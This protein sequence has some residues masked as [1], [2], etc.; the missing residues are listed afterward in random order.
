M[1]IQEALDQVETLEVLRLHLD[2]LTLVEMQGLL[3]TAIL[4]TMDKV[5]VVATEVILEALDILETLEMLVTQA[6]EATAV[7]VEEEAPD[8]ILQVI[9]DKVEVVVEEE[10]LA[11][12]LAILVTKATVL[13]MEVMEEVAVVPPEMEELEETVEVEEKTILLKAAEPAAVD[14]VVLAAPEVELEVEVQVHLDIMDQELELE[15]TATQVVQAVPTLAILG[16][17]VLPTVILLQ[18]IHQRLIQ[19]QLELVAL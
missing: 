17:L 18:W 13:V 16:V 1:Q 5:V 12:T 4:V 2:I 15:A 14:Q 7:P 10:T 9:M 8:R 19:S 3:E 11:G 6:T